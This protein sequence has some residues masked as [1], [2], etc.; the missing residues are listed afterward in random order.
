MGARSAV[1]ENI[2]DIVKQIYAHEGFEKGKMRAWLKK[3]IVGI[4]KES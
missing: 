4:I 3:Q 2:V 1:G